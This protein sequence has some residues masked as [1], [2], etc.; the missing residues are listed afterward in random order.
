MCHPARS[1]GP[2]NLLAGPEI[3][4]LPENTVQVRDRAPFFIFENHPSTWRAG[5]AKVRPKPCTIGGR[6]RAG[7]SAKITYL[8]RSLMFTG[9]KLALTLAFTVLVAVAFGVSC[10]KFFQ[11]NALESI[12]IQPPSVNLDVTAAQVFSAWGTYQDGSRSQIT[13]GVVW[14]SSDPSV[15]IDSG[16]KATGVFVTTSSATITGSAQGLSGTATVTVIGDVTSMSV[17]PTS[18]NISAG[19]NVTFT[20]A[21]SP[22]PPDYVTTGNGGTL[23]VSTVD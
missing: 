1:E 6:A 13:S 2:M 18:S 21:A 14:T 7:H 23:F 15:T 12:V 19:T 17:S 4:S 8:R 16:G 9:R 3:R 5:W 20:F 10:G 11:P 22:G